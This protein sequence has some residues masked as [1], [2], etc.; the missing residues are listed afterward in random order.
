MVATCWLVQQIT[1]LL[2][3]YVV[4]VMVSLFHIKLNELLVY[5]AYFCSTTGKD[6]EVAFR[7]KILCEA[8][9]LQRVAY[10]IFAVNILDT[11]FVSPQHRWRSVYL[12]AVI[13]VLS[14]ALH[15]VSFLLLLGFLLSIGGGSDHAGLQGREQ[16]EEKD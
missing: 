7:G 4:A 3:R 10:V 9:A 2:V 13:D 6:T 14:L 5:A 16:G 15:V 12:P 1:G 8:S 11:D